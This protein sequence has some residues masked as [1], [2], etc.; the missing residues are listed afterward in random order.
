MKY[1]N[2]MLS[3]IMAALLCV[4]S[5]WVIPIGAVPLSLASFVIYAVCA[6]CDLKRSI[7]AVSIYVLLGAI[8][9]PIFAGFV[10][11]VQVILGPTGGYVLGY[12]VAA[13]IIPILKDKI[14]L[15]ITLCIST[16]VIYLCGTM[17][18]MA[19]AEVKFAQAM[20]VC[21]LPFVVADI[22]KMVLACVCVPKIK[23]ALKGKL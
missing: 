1:K 8:G 18:Y 19:V 17:W 22:I 21:V 2:L 6:L 10:G 15:F 12:L 11:G 9:L 14:N 23:T 3:A 7:A 16:L 5:P 4:V 13:A 20:A